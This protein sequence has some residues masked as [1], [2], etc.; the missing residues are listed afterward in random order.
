MYIYIYIEIVDIYPL[1]M[2][3][4]QSCLPVFQRIEA[5]LVGPW[6]Q[7]WVQLGP[8]SPHVQGIQLG[9]P[10]DGQHQLI[11]QRTN[12]CAQGWDFG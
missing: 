10:K 11:V 3:I 5:W 9:G 1:E 6:V 7:P 12:S 2:L 8:G 4:F